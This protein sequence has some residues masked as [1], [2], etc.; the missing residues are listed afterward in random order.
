M[1]LF[2]G[3]LS[4]HIGRRCMMTLVLICAVL[5]SSIILINITFKLP[6]WT[7]FFGNACAGIGGGLNGMFMLIIAYTADV[8]EKVER[9]F[10][11]GKV[12]RR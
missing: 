10:R 8:T 11:I 3:A 6:M 2:Y 12:I 1:N 4:D 7:I 5:E 9:S